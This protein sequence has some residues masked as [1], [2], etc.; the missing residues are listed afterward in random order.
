MNQCPHT[1]M[2]RLLRRAIT[3]WPKTKDWREAALIYVIFAAL[4][5]PIGLGF[6]HLSF[7]WSKAPPGKLA[8]FTGIAFLMPALLEEL[9]FRVVLLPDPGP[10]T[11]KKTFWGWAGLS[12]VLFVGAHPLN[13]WLLRP[14]ARPVFYDPVFLILAGLLGLAC[15]VAYRRTRSL[16]PSV[17]MHW[18]TVVAWKLFLGGPLPVF[19][20]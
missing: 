19:G 7:G 3:S 14:T 13:A 10:E 12:W 16:W 6:G 17:G 5:L 9:I 4:A 15:T 8:L 2:Y 18:M 20:V 11:S 1:Q